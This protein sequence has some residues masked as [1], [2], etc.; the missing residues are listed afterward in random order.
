ME[1]KQLIEKI[2]SLKAIKP[3][4][5]WVIFAKSEIFKEERVIAEQ[6]IGLKE[7]W[8]G[9]RFM[10]SHKYAF[11]V[12]A[13]IL[14]LAG[15]FGFALKTVPGDALFAVR[16]ALEQGQAVFVPQSDKV[17]FDLAQANKRLEDLTKI[18]GNK[19]SRK[20]APAI[21]EYQ[22]SVSEVAKNLATETDKAKLKEIVSGVKDL[23]SKEKAIK[24]LGIEL[25]ENT[26]KDINL[27]GLITNEISKLEVKNITSEQR[28]LLIIAQS[29]L[30]KGEIADALD[31]ILE[32]NNPQS[33]LNP[34]SN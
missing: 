25:G 4:Q 27:I 13:V 9:F 10:F 32:L 14:I 17:K 5:E 18:A 26:D 28:S 2:K 15:T 23:E 33:I 8:L 30:E 19:D 7:L 12:V 3:R 11:S 34:E 21:D 29:K 31:I 22:A 6:R 24:S 16:K 20:L 1:E